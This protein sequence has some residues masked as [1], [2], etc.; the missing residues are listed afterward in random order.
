MR[1]LAVVALASIVVVGIVAESDAQGILFGRVTDATT[2]RAIAGASI[3]LDNGGGAMREEV[4]SD[5]G[6][7]VALGLPAGQ[8]TLTVQANQC[9]YI[10]HSE[11]IT[12]RSGRNPP[13]IVAMER[14][15]WLRS[16]VDEFT[17][18]ERRVAAIAGRDGSLM[19]LVTCTAT[20]VGAA[21]SF[22]D[23]RGIFHD[24][25]IEI[26]FDSETA[27]SAEWNDADDL[28]AIPE[29]GPETASRKNFWL[30]SLLRN[31][32]RL[33]FLYPKCHC[34]GRSAAG[35]PRLEDG[36]KPF[37]MPALPPGSWR[38]EG[39]GASLPVMRASAREEMRRIS[40]T[41][42][43]SSRLFAIHSRY[44]TSSSSVSFKPT[45]FPR[46]LRV[47]WW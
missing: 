22:M 37:V 39:H 30:M 17:D 47:Q 6:D 38:R 3:E 2:G 11:G 8:W 13:V 32:D 35:T 36:G 34:E 10:E 24:G 46:A 15:W 28:L 14:G 31:R 1:E 45:V 33:G 44:R 18:V 19:L 40:L 9:C 41:I 21:L 12:V 20:G 43:S 25:Q 4:T 27:E 16:E 42:R 23:G 26:R 29:R 7:Y 5:L